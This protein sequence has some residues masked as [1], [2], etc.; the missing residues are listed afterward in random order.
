MVAGV[1]AG[2]FDL[3]AGPAGPRLGVSGIGVCIGAF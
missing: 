3:G 1:P 2:K